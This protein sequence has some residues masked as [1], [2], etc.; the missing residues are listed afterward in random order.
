MCGSVFDEEH[1]LVC[2][3][4]SKILLKIIDPSEAIDFQRSKPR[5]DYW[6]KWKIVKYV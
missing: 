4:E 5:L 1:K 2:N 3:N 6:S